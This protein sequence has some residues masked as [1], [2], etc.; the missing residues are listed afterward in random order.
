MA[1]DMS[2]TTL[3]YHQLRTP[4]IAYPTTKSNTGL[5]ADWA[6]GVVHA[7]TSH[8]APRVA[9]TS[10]SSS[11]CE[12]VQ[13]RPSGS[14]T[15]RTQTDSPLYAYRSQPQGVELD[16]EADIF[17]SL[18]PEHNIE[19]ATRVSFFLLIDHWH[20]DKF[21]LCQVPSKRNID[22]A[23]LSGTHTYKKP[24]HEFPPGASAVLGLASGRKP[25]QAKPK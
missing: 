14:H 4:S 23:N 20:V 16:N 9:L 24:R 25:S 15:T 5:I 21:S 11:V 10:P 22:L 1:L 8:P 13:D 17:T 12:I 3:F 7:T 18:V 6:D 19:T 2:E